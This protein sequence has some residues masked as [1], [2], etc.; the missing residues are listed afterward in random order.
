MAKESTIDKIEYG[1]VTYE[2]Q[3]STARN[4]IN[5]LSRRVA[6]IDVDVTQ[7][8]RDE[9]ARAKAA[10]QAEETRAKA[11]E[12]AIRDSY[13]PKIEGKG[14]S[15][16]DFTPDIQAR[17]TE[18]SIMQGATATRDGFKGICNTPLA[19]Q[20]NH[21]W[22]GAAEWKP[23]TNATWDIDGQMAKADKEKLDKMSIDP[24]MEKGKVTITDNVIVEIIGDEN[25]YKR[26]VTTTFNADGSIKQEV[27]MPGVPKV[28]TRLTF[29][30]GL[31]TRTKE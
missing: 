19:N 11:A 28:T 23:F 1:G 9:E 26:K 4:D 3:D 14:L 16:L 31:I 25:S 24:S 20:Q 8:V 21:Y 27:E 5:V 22:S 6:N 12:Q 15:T 13:V 2:F 7:V 30:N 29:D 17:I 18:P 10:E